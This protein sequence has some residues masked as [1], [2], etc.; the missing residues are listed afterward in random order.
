V[1]VYFWRLGRRYIKDFYA[2]RL[3][4][5]GFGALANKHLICTGEYISTKFLD[6]PANFLTPELEAELLAGFKHG[7]MAGKPMNLYDLSRERFDRYFFA[8]ANMNDIVRPIG[9]L[10]GF[11]Y[12]YLGDIVSKECKSF[13]PHESQQIRRLG[14]I[15]RYRDLFDEGICWV[16]RNLTTKEFVKSTAV[17]LEPRLHRGYEI[18]G[19]GFGELLAMRISW[20]TDPSCA[21]GCDGYEDGIHRGVWAGHRFD[22]VPLST[23]RDQDQD[24]EWRDVSE[25]VMKEVTGIWEADLGVEW[26]RILRSHLRY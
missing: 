26:K 21:M 1:N 16:L 3:A 8:P 7:S 18:D 12:S 2:A 23:L 15:K 19:P 20:S 25:E 6:Y 11:E 17:A 14:K 5:S 4:E 24:S 13:P 10:G 22:I 9:W